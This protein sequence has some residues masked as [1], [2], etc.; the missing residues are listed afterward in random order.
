MYTKI[1]R[2]LFILSVVLGLISSSSGVYASG[3]RFKG[4]WKS[5][6]DAKSGTAIC[7][8]TGKR[9][10]ESGM[11]EMDGIRESRPCWQ[12]GYVKSCNFPSKN[13]CMI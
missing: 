4:D 3:I 7:Q 12:Y 6:I 9:C 8:D 10:V 11:K 13:D 1:V 5:M 2:L